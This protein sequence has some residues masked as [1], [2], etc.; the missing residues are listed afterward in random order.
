MFLLTSSL[1]SRSR[2]KY[3]VGGKTCKR[4]PKMSVPDEVMSQVR[5]TLYTRDEGGRNGEYRK[6][7]VD[8]R[9]KLALAVNFMTFNA[10][11]MVS[12]R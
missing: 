5:Q 7:R 6:N 11:P 2:S 10:K 4:W 3:G 12:A 8:G 1:L 9:R